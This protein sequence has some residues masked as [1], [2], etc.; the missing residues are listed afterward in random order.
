MRDNAWWTDVSGPSRFMAAAA[1]SAAAQK[2]CILALPSEIPFEDE[3]VDTLL[4][5]VENE[6]S[7]QEVHVIDGFAGNVAEY[8]LTSYCRRELRASFR[9]KPGY[10]AARFLAESASSVMHGRGFIVRL[11]DAAAL[12]EWLPFVSEYAS[13]V[14]GNVSPAVFFLVVQSEVAPRTIKG[15][16]LL[17]YRDYSSPFDSYAYCAIRAAAISEPNLIKTYLAELASCITGGNAEQAEKAIYIY[18]EFLQDPVCFARKYYGEFGEDEEELR[19]RVWE[20]QLKCIFPYLEGYR[21]SFVAQYEP[22][23]EEQLPLAN[24]LG[25]DYVSAGDVE[26]GA[27]LFMTGSGMLRIPRGEYEKLKLFASARNKL[28]HLEVL[29]YSEIRDIVS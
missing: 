29:D 10:T 6:L 7:G 23:I 26:L 17:D 5:R 24:P 15:V 20:A 18:R 11:E 19:R 13:G 8:F 28:A 4:S 9:P 16:G 1:R 21:C 25:D 3:F 2:S 27:L 14:S 22:L 12:G